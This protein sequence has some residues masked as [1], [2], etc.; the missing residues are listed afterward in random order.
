MCSGGGK[1]QVLPS[2]HARQPPVSVLLSCRRW[3]GVRA[4]RVRGRLG[5]VER[6]AQM[7]PPAGS[8][9]PVTEHHFELHGANTQPGGRR[10]QGR[11]VGREEAR[12]R[13]CVLGAATCLAATHASWPCHLFWRVHGGVLQNKRGEVQSAHKTTHIVLRM[14]RE[15]LE[16]A[17]D[18]CHSAGGGSTPLSKAKSHPIYPKPCSCSLAQSWPPGWRVNS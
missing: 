1:W 12:V 17:R 3:M 6:A 10:G 4:A 15:H 14:K 9:T 11:G 8:R 13:G 2:W 7:S 5:P 18:S 16:R